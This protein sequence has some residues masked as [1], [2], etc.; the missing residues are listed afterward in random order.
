[1]RMWLFYVKINGFL[2]KFIEILVSYDSKYIF[3]Y[4]K[5]VYFT[6]KNIYCGTIN[7]Y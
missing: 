1:M 2:V 5:L 6:L 4:K 7:Y 3:L